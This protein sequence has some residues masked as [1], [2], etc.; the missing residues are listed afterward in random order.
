MNLNDPYLHL[1]EVEGEKALTFAKTETERSVAHFKKSPYFNG[2]EKDFRSLL[3]ATD[4][5]PMVNLK[6]GE[7]YNFW[8]DEKSVRG[9][10]RKTSVESY[11]QEKP[12]WDVILDID[13]LAKKENENW[14]W[15]GASTLYPN[16]ELALVYLSR[17]G[18]DAVVVRE[19]NM[20]TRKFVK[21]GFSLPE[22]KGSLRWKDRD[23][24]FVAT[25]FGPGTMTDSGYPR[26][27]K[28]WKRGTPLSAAKLILEGQA[29]DMSVGSYAGMDGEKRHIVHTVRLGF[30][31]SKKWYENESGQIY[32]IELPE[33]SELAGFFQD[34]IFVELRQDLEKFKA[35]SVVF[36]PVSEISKG[37]ES[38]KSLK[39][40]FSPSDKKY[41]QW[42][43]T[44]KNY[45][46]LNVIDDILSKME[47]VTFTDDHNFKVEPVKLG[48]EGMANLVSTEEESDLFLA[49]YVDFLTPTSIYIGDASKQDNSLKLEK[50]SPTRFKSE[51]M[52]VERFEVKSDDGTLIPYFVIAKKDIAL[53][54]KNPTLLYGY[55]GFQAPMQ[56]RYLAIEG[57]SWLE[58]G[59]VYVMANLRGG[60]EFGP[61]WH[62]SVLKENRY[63]VYEDFVAISEDLIRRGFT[64]KDHLGI[65][66]RSNGGLLTGATFTARPDLFKAAIVGVPLL[67][68]LRYHKLL[69]GAS[70]MDEYG[71][72]D[73]AKMRE[74]ILRYSPYQ[75]VSA[76][77]KYPEVFIMTSTKDD[78]VHPGHARKMVAR[79][80]EQGH[81]VFYYE[82][83]EGGHGGSANIE[84]SILWNTLEY[85]YLWEKLDNK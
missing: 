14:V 54:G 7:L 48:H 5:I 44:T 4:R 42:M 16:H 2:L 77:E 74:A 73:D 68:M 1:E 64:S 9:Q 72:P 69:A 71:D 32:P 18:K 34:K 85:T 30:Y 84:Q 66:G 51:D 46:V 61:K 3:L 29:T 57:K 49:Q 83:T 8:Q 10:W 27:T 60:G 41:F 78:R 75:R 39:L 36:M 37:I 63:K 13:A 26:Q 70:W 55:G 45:I 15:K 35:G 40:L 31:S 67:D 28:L 79:M 12:K 76:N 53:D 43:D 38:R 52:K 6:N 22:A 65:S 21:D 62:Q 58:R 20:R 50:Q 23:H 81:E 82:N 19:F 11:Q 80:K 17:G 25:D 56:P 47:K 24:V 33:D 59:G